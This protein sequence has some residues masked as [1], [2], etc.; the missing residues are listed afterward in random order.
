MICGLNCAKHMSIKPIHI[1][2]SDI[3]S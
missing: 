1:Q 2:Q 3:L